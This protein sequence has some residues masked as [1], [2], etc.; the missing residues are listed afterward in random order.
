MRVPSACPLNDLMPN[1]ASGALYG[2]RAAG[3]AGVVAWNEV[4][5]VATSMFQLRLS[6]AGAVAQVWS[7]HVA[8]DAISA[9]S[10]DGVLWDPLPILLRTELHFRVCLLSHL[11]PPESFCF[12]NIVGL[13]VQTAASAR[14]RA[15]L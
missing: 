14:A 11:S 12:W 3:H 6:S 4:T 5:H 8:I 13:H 15:S 7:V 10:W 2:L 1:S 9:P